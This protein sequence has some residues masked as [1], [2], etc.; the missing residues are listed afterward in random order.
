M[1]ALCAA[2]FREM[3]AISTVI[4]DSRQE[5]LTTAGFVL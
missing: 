2:T 3:T 1:I 5:V 4:L